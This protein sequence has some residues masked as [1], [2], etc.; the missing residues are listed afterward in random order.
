MNFRGARRGSFSL[1]AAAGLCPELAAN[2]L[3]LEPQEAQA[4]ERSGDAFQELLNVTCGH[5]L[6]AVAGE[7]AVFD[8]DAPQLGRLDDAGWNALRA[9]PGAVGFTVEGHP[10]LLR[11]QL[12]A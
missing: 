12:D 11:L 10:V 6:T 4:L 9:L 5:V 7:S 8:L 1:A 2:V 3:G